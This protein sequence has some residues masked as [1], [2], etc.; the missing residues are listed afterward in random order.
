MAL[1]YMQ[2][3]ISLDPLAGAEQAADDMSDSSDEDDEVS[4]AV[5]GLQLAG[6]GGDGQFEAAVTHLVM[7]VQGAGSGLIGA[8]LGGIAPLASAAGLLA[9][10]GTADGVGGVTGELNI[11]AGAA[12]PYIRPGLQQ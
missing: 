5:A 7:A 9:K 12:P 11:P 8:M 6:N 10:L 1:P 4:A 2:Q 3:L